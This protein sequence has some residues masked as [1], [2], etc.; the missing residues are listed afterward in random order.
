MKSFM[1][2]SSPGSG[3]SVTADRCICIY[4]YMYIHFL[5][6]EAVSWAHDKLIRYKRSTTNMNTVKLQAGYPWPCTSWCQKAVCNWNRIKLCISTHQ[7]WRERKIQIYII[8]FTYFSRVPYAGMSVLIKYMRVSLRGTVVVGAVVVV[9]GG[10]PEQDTCWSLSVPLDVN[11]TKPGWLV[12]MFW[13]IQSWYLETL[14]YTPGK[15]GTAQLLPKLTMP[16]WIHWEPCLRSSGPP[17]SPC[18]V[19]A[20][21]Y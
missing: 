7:S 10:R 14:A 3:F 16:T 20:D 11:K 17:E 19:Q 13:L 21:I 15:F 6:G 5:P 18:A 8:I 9:T 12:L 1:L 4:I 2:L